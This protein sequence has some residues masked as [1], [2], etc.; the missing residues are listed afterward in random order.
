M[1]RVGRTG[2][3][4]KRKPGK[5]SGDI[6]FESDG[7]ISIKFITIKCSDLAHVISQPVHS[8]MLYHRLCI[9]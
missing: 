1:K 7:G 2:M 9:L 8:S 6:K 5:V 3:N 4:W